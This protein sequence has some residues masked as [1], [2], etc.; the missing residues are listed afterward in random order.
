[1][2]EFAKMSEKIWPMILFWDF[3]DVLGNIK[4][5]TNY[6]GIYQNVREN[7]GQWSFFEIFWMF[8]VVLNHLNS[9]I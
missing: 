3:L 5:I 4:E 7:M 9:A 1:M 8:S 6:E 2:K